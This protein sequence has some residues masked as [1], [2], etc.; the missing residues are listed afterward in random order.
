MCHCTADESLCGDGLV[1]DFYYKKKN[2][3]IHLYIKKNLNLKNLRKQIKMNLSG[4]FLY[5]FLFK[6]KNCNL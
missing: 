5:L 4:K 1:T 2:K 6:K 3:M